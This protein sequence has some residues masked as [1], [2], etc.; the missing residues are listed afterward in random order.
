MCLRNGTGN[1]FP[2]M[3][4]YARG[5]LRILHR[6]RADGKSFHSPRTRILVPTHYPVLPQL[7]HH[8]RRRLPQS[9]M[10]SNFNDSYRNVVGFAPN[11]PTIH[12]QIK[13]RYSHGHSHR[14]H[15]RRFLIALRSIARGI[16]RRFRA[17]AVG[18][19]TE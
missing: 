1:I 2:I 13:Q 11:L 19:P 8:R 9:F 7:S 17:H 12:D 14:L 18:M 4:W 16:C 6:P 3:E 15:H 5:F 10:G